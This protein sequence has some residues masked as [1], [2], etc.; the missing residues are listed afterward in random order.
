[1]A[2]SRVSMV[3]R[4]GRAEASC[5]F[6][7]QDKTHGYVLWVQAECCQRELEVAIEH[8]SQGDRI[9]MRRQFNEMDAVEAL[10]AH[11]KAVIVEAVQLTA[12]PLPF[13]PGKWL[14][15]GGAD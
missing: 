15:K 11:Y 8:M 14:S 12:D 7:K 1:M 6:H 13:G 9:A 10:A 4:Q 3:D 5:S 2:A